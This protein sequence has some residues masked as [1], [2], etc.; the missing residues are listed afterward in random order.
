[1]K[2][3]KS[4]AALALVLALLLSPV[5]RLEAKAEE[6]RIVEGFVYLV[7]ANAPNSAAEVTDAGVL[8]LW[9]RLGSRRQQ[10]LVKQQD[11]SYYF[12]DAWTGLAVEVPDGTPSP[13][14]QLR[15]AEFT[16][17]DNQLWELEAATSSTYYIRSKLD[18]DYVMDNY[19]ATDKNGAR[20]AVDKYNGGSNQR[21]RLYIEQASDGHT[22]P[23]S[24]GENEAYALVPLHSAGTPVDV[25]VGNGYV[26]LYN[27]HRGSNQAW[28]LKPY[29]GYYYIQSAATGQALTVTR[30]ESLPQSPVY[31]KPL[32]YADSQLWKLEPLGDGSYCFRSKLH[33]SYVLEAP[34]LGGHGTHLTVGGFNGW[35]HQRF[36]LLHLST[37]E[38]TG[39][40]GASRTDC[41]G[42]DWSMWDGS[43]DNRWYYNNKNAITFTIRTAS[44]LAGL[45]QLVRDGID[46]FLGK[47]I[48]L[49]SD[50]N[51]CGVEWRR[52][53]LP[54]LPFRGSFN[55]QGH[56]IV[57]LSIT[58]SSTCDGFFGVINSGCVGNFAIKGS[59]SGDMYVGGVVGALDAGHVVNVYS[60]VSLTKA[61]DDDEGG[62]C[63]KMEPAGMIDHCTQNARINS[64]DQ[65]PNRGGICGNA[66]GTIRYCVNR[67]S[68]DCNWDCLGGIAGACP[69]GRIE[70]CLNEGQ[71]SGGSD[72]QYAGGICGKA[73]GGARLFCCINS[74]TVF[75]SND[76]DIGGVC[77]ECSGDSAVYACV[78]TGRVYGDDRIGGIV[79]NGSCTYCFNMGYVTGDDD[80]GAI[81]G[82]GGRNDW[83]RALAY[84]SAR[85]H[86]SGDFNGSEWVTA[87]QVINGNAC[88]DLNRRDLTMDFSGQYGF[89]ND[90]FRQN[91]GADVY[92]TFS[93]QKITKS[94]NNYRNDYYSVRVTSTP[95]YGTVFGAGNYEYGQVTLKA[96]PADGC[97]F[98]HYEVHFS[99]VGAEIMVNGLQYYP[100]KATYIYTTPEL[101]LS[102]GLVSSYNVDAVFTVYDE[103]PADLRQEVR[104]EV[105]CV[106]DVDGWNADTIPIYLIDSA[107]EKHLWEVS[108]DKLDGDGEK[109]SHTFQLGTAS[110]VAV[111]AWPD[112][113]GGFTYHDLG[114][115]ARM[116]VNNAG[117]AIES[118]EVMIRSYPFVSSKY[119]NDYMHITFDDAG[120]SSVGYLRE[121]G[122]LDVKGTYTTCSEAWATARLLGKKAVIRLDSVWLTTGR[123]SL[124][125]GEITLDLNGYPLIRA[126]K[127]TQD[128]GEVISVASGATL[129]VVDSKPA[130]KS[131]S[132]FYGG[133]IQ[134][135]RSDN[136][137]GLINVRGTLDMKGGA[138]Y[139]GG[140]TEK[141]GA[142]D[143]DGGAVTLDGTL[144][145]DCWANKATFSENNGG[146]IAVRNSG[147]V[148]LKNCTVRNCHAGDSGGGFYV[149]KDGAKLTLEN[150]AISACRAT[151]NEGGA[152]CQTGGTVTHAGGSIQNC[153]SEESSG[154]AVYQSGGTLLS[155][156][157]SFRSNEANKNGGG[158][159][160]GSGNLNWFI[161][162]TFEG[163]RCGEDGG[164]IWLKDKDHLYLEDC[165]VTANAAGD[166]AGGIDAGEDA[167]VDVFGKIVIKNNDGK[168]RF[169]N[170]VLKG[171][172]LLY[173]Q[174]L[175]PGSEIHLRSSK[176]K[177]VK[178]GEE[179]E[180]YYISQRHMQQYLTGDGVTLELRD[181][182]EV[183]SGLTASGFTGGVKAIVIGAA[184]LLAALIAGI[185]QMRKKRK[186]EKEDA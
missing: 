11:D 99:F 70:Y 106:D 20:I 18:R 94:G 116:W 136:G 134:G 127:K 96:Q 88:Y 140:T 182:K 108:K 12:L 75:S 45:S 157:V 144:I 91:I 23:L 19:Y 118:G 55:G 54:G 150:T 98:D 29:D 56:A 143:C 53:G 7:P 90:V 131:C 37:V 179:N 165:T 132:A 124:D 148:S 24:Y 145:S 133:S 105:E 180:A 5:A 155:R 46:S 25:S 117:T 43:S 156:N 34:A 31:Q 147:S 80:T 100:M 63:G 93:G 16:G 10:F 178:L 149:E 89:Y 82:K 8:Q 119:N 86:G 122:S 14:V 62:I 181:A 164:A 35:G 174:G 152:I 113:G 154:G 125:S 36:R 107:G 129:H 38:P 68:V 60:E 79:G 58:T 27:A 9:E 109:V 74:G 85:I 22:D 153:R 21:F 2:H 137:A 95:G 151:E 39:E 13:G 49:D 121:D 59:V 30:P 158:V 50:I 61:A 169:D 171:D 170:L 110:P 128:D 172:A 77:G 81:A 40:W 123:L 161:G 166:E 130:R 176:T 139:N 183:K 44:E 78:N 3:L 104:L 162:C 51:L 141:G 146:G 65:D 175:K 103:T 114:L 71:V 15:L 57:G 73:T 52:I 142:I 138:L 41:T 135:G 72:S 111:E 92:P 1:M 87:E 126:M 173:D 115:K 83:C 163:N 159:C 177:D 160:T 97:V 4:L 67:S 6:P 184:L 33:N 101:T 66:K 185:V 47:T 112:F 26:Q 42:S 120:N 167:N 69:G 32:T 186:G 64:G 28:Y 76:D 84:S 48:C 17:A 102:R 168:D